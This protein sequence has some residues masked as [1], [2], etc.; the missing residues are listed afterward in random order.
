[1]PVNIRKTSDIPDPF[2]LFACVE[3]ENEVAA[4]LESLEGPQNQTRFSIVAWGAKEHV[5]AKKGKTSGTISMEFHDPVEIFDRLVKKS[6][7]IELPGKYGGGPIGYVSYDAVR[8][9]EKIKDI[10]PELEPW[11]DFEFFVPENMVVYDHYQGRAYVYGDV[12]E[13]GCSVGD[14][15]S[16]KK[17]FESM[18]KEEFEKAVRE[19]LEY[20]RSGYAFQV[21]LSRFYYYNFRGSPL[22]FYARLRKVNP[23]PY[24]FYL[25]FGERR[26]VGASPETLFSLQDG[27]IESYPIAGSRPRGRTPEED[28]ALERE[29]LNSEKER[30]EHL[31]LVDLARNDLGKVS[32][33]GSVK[34]PDLL[35]VEKYSYVQ[36]LVSRV[37]GTLKNNATPY[38]VL[39]ATFPA[40]T[41]SGAPKPF[42]MNLIETLEP[43]KRGPYAGAVG[44]F[45]VNSNA[46]FAIAIR[47][48]FFYG[49]KVRIQAGAGLV[50][51][52]IPENEYYETEFKMKALRIA[53]GD[54]A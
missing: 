10:K 17:E 5:Q 34:V 42:A 28:F 25:K 1:M 19:V 8:Y 41:V 27:V 47:S 14:A 15:F 29:L 11:P 53:G 50:Y 24:M 26:L 31:M 40:G 44:F 6:E 39:K 51:D 32:Y 35:Y 45:S 52:S 36:H 38:D 54:T 2:S 9:W 30:A 20:I 33:M 23:S 49:D 21:V 48:A 43:Y 13:K 4:L 46:E 12:V 16:L 22:T 18:N 7:E 37:I 3:N